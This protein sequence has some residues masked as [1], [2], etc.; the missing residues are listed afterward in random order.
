MFIWH[1]G[2]TA[3]AAW[4]QTQ[5]VAIDA[6]M[7]EIASGNIARVPGTAVFMTRTQQ[8]APPVMVWH[9]RQNRSLHERLFVLTIS[10]APVP[11]IGG[12]HRLTFQQMAPGFWRASAQYGFMEHLD[13]PALLRTAHTQ[14][15]GIDLADVIYYV[16]HETI[17]PRE[18]AG[19]LPR[20]VEE[21][22]AF[23]QR[24]SAHLSEYLKLPPDAVV[25][26]GRQIPV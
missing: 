20:W 2:A 26:L 15:C 1:R 25:E 10:I 9:V 11:W 24:N 3:V 23:M 5:A 13:I 6:F 16:G 17:T 18:G 4:L 8:D 22:F 12:S 7:T 21:L 14:G 19:A